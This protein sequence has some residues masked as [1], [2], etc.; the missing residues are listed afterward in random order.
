MEF[1]TVSEDC[2]STASIS[3]PATVTSSTEAYGSSTLNPSITPSISASIS[4]SVSE[5]SPSVTSNTGTTISPVLSSLISSTTGTFSSSLSSLNE[6]FTAAGTST[7]A[8]LSSANPTIGNFSSISS[9][10]VTVPTNPTSPSTN[11]P[12]SSSGS[13]SFPGTSVN[14]TGPV[15]LTVSPQSVTRTISASETLA[16]LIVASVNGHP[17]LDELQFCRIFSVFSR[18]KR[19]RNRDSSELF[20]A[21]YL[22]FDCDTSIA[23]VHLFGADHID[24]SLGNIFW[25]S[26]LGKPSVELI[27]FTS[28]YVVQYNEPKWTDRTE[29][30]HQPDRC[31]Y[32]VPGPPQPFTIP[33][34]PTTFS[35]M[36]ATSSLGSGNLSSQS[37][38]TVSESRPSSSTLNLSFSA[39]P[40]LQFDTGP[41]SKQFRYFEHWLGFFSSG[42]L[43]DNTALKSNNG[44][45]SFVS[46]T[47]TGLTSSIRDPE[48]RSEWEW[49][50]TS[51][52][53]GLYTTFSQLR[54][55]HH[56]L[57]PL[58]LVQLD[59]EWFEL[60]RISASFSDQLR[61]RYRL[62]FSSSQHKFALIHLD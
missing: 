43:L 14:S 8:S 60:F 16:T 2:S 17:V 27:F 23:L 24:P 36:T 3:S 38:A 5:T 31:H 33:P 19:A 44:A 28:I 37:A 11:I 32:S 50:F 7:P 30:R 18:S 58:P 40:A 41:H 6:S 42:W 1:G 55:G 29:C 20:R 47:I 62:F 26:H 13:Y 39:F 25:I 56:K 46:H 35:S 54:F 45:S 22:D 15:T 4:S 51:R 21:K 52:F 53:H 61:Y 9:F 12:T 10:S 59:C 34:R 49:D 57:S 48:L